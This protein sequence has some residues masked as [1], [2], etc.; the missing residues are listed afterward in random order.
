MLVLVSD[1]F[2]HLGYHILELRGPHTV[3]FVH[4]LVTYDAVLSQGRDKILRCFGVLL[5]L[6]T[7]RFSC[8]LSVLLT[9]IG[10]SGCLLHWSKKVRGREDLVEILKLLAGLDFVR[11][12][13]RLFINFINMGEAVHNECAE[14]D[15]VGDFIL[16]NAKAFEVSESF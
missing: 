13:D 7:L 6:N 4:L 15:G 2:T 14:E 10:S 8:C 16:F 1:L 5:G 12:L 3:Q 11:L 9:L